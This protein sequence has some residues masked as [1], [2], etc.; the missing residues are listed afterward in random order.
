MGYTS[1]PSNAV[2]T[3]AER[4]ELP[5]RLRS[6]LILASA[7]PS[8]AVERKF[9]PRS[10]SL[11]QSTRNGHLRNMRSFNTAGPVVA[12]DH[13]CIPPLERIDLE[14]VLGLIHD[15][16][17]FILHAPRQTGKT[18]TLK[19][20]QDHLNSG[21]E[22]DYRCLYVNLESGQTARE[23]VG[24]AM[25]AILDEFALRAELVLEDDF[26]QKAWREVP[27]MSGSHGALKRVLA[28]WSLASPRPLV[29]LIDEIDALIGDSLLS[30]LR[31][32]RSGYDMRPRSFPHSIV[33]CGVR[34]VRD[35]PIHPSSD[36]EMIPGGSAFNISATSLRLGDFDRGE[37]EALLGQHTEETGQQFEPAAV[38]R[39]CTQSAGQPS[40]VNA[41]CWH[42][43][44]ESPRG[45]D[46]SRPISEDDILAAQE[47]LIQGRVVHLDQLTDKLRDERVQRVIEPMLSGA[48]HRSCTTHDLEYVR[49]LGLIALD[50]P[51]RIA[52]PIYA[53]AVPRELTYVI[54]QDL[55]VEPAWY[56][57]EDGALNLDKLLEAFQEYFRESGEHWLKPFQYRE[58]GPQLL[59]QAFLQRVLSGG[60]RIEREYGLG[61]Q[62]V[63]LLIRW[64]R[65]GG[66]QRFVIEC[67]ILRGSLDKTLE[68]GLPQTASYMDRCGADPGHLVI[69]YR[70]AK[71]WQE[72]VY[73]RSEEFEGTPVEVWGM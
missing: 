49:D 19:A 55:L 69:F 21:A 8:R 22:G 17:Y 27:V 16:K 63:D 51:P 30:V 47:V 26:V 70:S 53:E 42:A 65:P 56:V 46:R 4:C 44:F 61:R 11:S 48:A 31:Q 2:W 36:G 34:N 3:A 5:S 60:G 33:L 54:Q 73:R 66:E 12:Q 14:Y 38:E 58:A 6:H 20:L 29:L 15:Q 72:K 41:L 50:P 7:S 62:R 37:V 39:I 24:R 35:Y 18:S 64:P 68:K 59:L 52:N 1:A 9:R 67:K 43:C 57:D 32:L 13:Y 23:D 40:L 10:K 45:R 71:P 25:Q 28:K